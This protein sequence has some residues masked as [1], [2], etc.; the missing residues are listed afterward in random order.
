MPR[1][2]GTGPQ[3][4]GAMTGRG[5]GVCTDGTNVYG[6]GTGLGLG[7]GL[8]LGRGRGSYG[9]RRGAGFGG[10]VVNNTAGIT[11]QEYLAEQKEALEKRLEI[12]NKQLEEK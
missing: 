9:C 2:D 10:V 1:R 3:G 8:G 11:G 12:I 5:L 6:R 4:V 7:L